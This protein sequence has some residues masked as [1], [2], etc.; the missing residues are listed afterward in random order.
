MI[1]SRDSGNIYNVLLY[2]ALESVG[3]PY[4]Q[5][6]FSIA[7][8]L[9]HRPRHRFHYLHFHWPEIFF[10]IRPRAP[11]KLFGMKGYLRLHAFWWLAKRRGYK[12]VWT[13]HEVDVHD[14]QR[15]TRFHMASRRLLWRWADVVF[16][17]TP[18]VRAEAERRWG[19]RPHVHT[20][21]IGSYDGAYPAT[22]DRSAARRR[23]GIPEG[24]FAFVFFGNIRPYKGI[25]VL[26]EAFRAVQPRHPEAHLILAG[27]PYSDAYAGAVRRACAGLANT[28]LVLE[29]VPDADVQLYLRA[30]DCFVAPYKYIETC[31]AIYLALA[32][33]LP[34]I[35]K[36][37]GN[38]TEFAPYDIGVLLRDT[39]ETEAAMRRFLAMPPP[40]LAALRANTRAASGAFA[41]ERL[42]PRYRDA[43]AAFEAT[44]G[45][46]VH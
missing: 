3:L 34:V 33:D 13:V 23:L 5:I 39:G 10:V 40:Q 16:T 27:N 24:A 30:A 4:V 26:I 44:G 31:S 22:L 25:E 19:P 45:R 32:F 21:P 42:A 36:A 41:W 14:L 12:L 7:Y 35:I 28:H 8:L 17:H 20:I 15:H 43:F 29:H 38:V 18:D 9:R 1:P 2:R 11:H 46:R 37:E 6:P